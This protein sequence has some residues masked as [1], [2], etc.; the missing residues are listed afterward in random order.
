MA[1]ENITNDLIVFIE[2]MGSM[3]EAV[4]GYRA[5]CVAS[6]FSAEAAESMAVCLHEQLIR[7]AFRDVTR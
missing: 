6:G 1:N 4:A 5:K 2:T 7:T 3:I